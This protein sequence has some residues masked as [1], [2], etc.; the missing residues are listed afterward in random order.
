M[1]F[2]KQA[3][4]ISQKVTALIHSILLMKVG[5]SMDALPFQG[6]IPNPVCLTVCLNDQHLVLPF[7]FS[8]NF[9]FEVSTN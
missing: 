9:L 7:S 3:E 8:Q 4:I 1:R 5:M 6:A 2:L